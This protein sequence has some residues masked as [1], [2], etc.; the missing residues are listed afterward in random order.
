M[1]ISEQPIRTQL[2][3]PRDAYHP[4]FAATIDVLQQSIIRWNGHNSPTGFQESVY[5]HAEG[6]FGWLRA[7]NKSFPALHAEIDLQQVAGYL[8][9]HD[10]KEI[11]AG[12]F[13]RR[14]TDT[15]EQERQ[16]HKVLED[17]AFEATWKHILPQEAHKVIYAYDDPNNTSNEV[18]FAR[19][20]DKAHSS[21][22]GLRHF[23]NPRLHGT[24]MD[25]EQ[26]RTYRKTIAAMHE[27]LHILRARLSDDATQE[28]TR[29]VGIVMDRFSNAGYEELVSEFTFHG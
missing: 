25:D 14:G 27:P 8:Y 1:A 22:T 29:L 19:A 26:I 6:M 23:Y 28:L 3:H 13:T 12:D 24:G 10:F 15:Y 5:D 11:G 21:I 20:L 18:L 17:H 16:A 4:A 9:L 2:Y 7:I